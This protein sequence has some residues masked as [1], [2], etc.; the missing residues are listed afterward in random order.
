MYPIKKHIK[1]YFNYI[2]VFFWD[3]NHSLVLF[4]CRRKR[5]IL[6]LG[7]DGRKPQAPGVLPGACGIVTLTGSYFN[8]VTPDSFSEVFGAIGLN[9][10]C[11][12]AVKADGDG[13]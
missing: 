11:A 13:F 4:A 1:I 7:T 10:K 2:F 8:I 6:L 5:N 9:D 12:S 3:F